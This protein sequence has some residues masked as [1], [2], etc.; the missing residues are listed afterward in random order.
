VRE[1]LAALGGLA[2]RLRYQESTIV[3]SVD[4]TVQTTPFLGKA[5][6]P[7]WK[8]RGGLW[9]RAP[10]YPAP[11]MG[12][13]FVRAF[14]VASAALMWAGAASA[15][16]PLARD[17]RDVVLKVN[18]KGE[19]LVSYAVGDRRR[20]VLV[21]GAVDARA[22]DPD[23]PQVQF[24]LDHSGGWATY[25]RAYWRTF[26]SGC[27]P[28]DGAPLPYLVAA[29]KAPD[30]SYWALQSWQ[31]RLPLLGFEPWLPSQ[32][33]YELHISHWTDSPARL[34]LFSKWT[35][36]GSQR[37]VFGRLTY[38]GSPVHGFSSS[39]AGDPRD[40]YGRNVYIDT[41]DSPYGPGWRR[42]TGILAHRPTG[43]FCHSFVP[44]IPPTGYPSRAT[45]PAGTGRYYR[46][47]AI[48]PGVTPIV[49]DYSAG[50]PPFDR[51]NASHRREA[52]EQ[53]ETFDAVMAGDRTCARER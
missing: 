53:N 29:C 52:Q 1:G 7:L 23:T 15:S 13:V 25:R 35:Y 24:R 44:Q 14:A 27:R 49:I 36:G 41:L 43:T 10:R 16:A 37:G 46:A 3:L 4:I 40:R 22:P 34:Q 6:A 11:P 38:R 2:G 18:R 21:W 28:Y 26:K 12:V 33:V 31:R 47:A 50:L 48:G 8:V 51:S 17:A 19:A 9:K 42:E 30:G 45:R 32:R 20:R 39:R 5:C